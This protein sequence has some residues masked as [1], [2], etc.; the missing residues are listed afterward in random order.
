[1]K[2]LKNILVGAAV[3]LCGAVA[4]FGQ[5]GRGYDEFNVP[6]TLL[7]YGATNS[8]GTGAGVGNTNGSLPLD[9]HRFIGMA[10]VDISVPGTNG[11]ASG[12]LTVTPQSSPDTTNW[13]SLPNYAVIS[14]TYSVNVTNMANT[15]EV[16]TNQYM[17]PGTIVTNTASVNLEAGYSLTSL[18][19][20]NVGGFT[21][22]V[23]TP[24][25]LGFQVQAVTNRYFRLNIALS[26]TNWFFGGA[27][28]TAP[29]TTYIAPIFP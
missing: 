20:T 26:G 24:I 1:M 23:N 21:I 22:P 28:F 12:T 13:Y 10:K 18:A 17:L 19:Y 14:N 6:R 8:F 11:V 15:N 9:L 3:L 16:G 25:E 29:T 27:Y 4:A 7:I 2:N 5:G